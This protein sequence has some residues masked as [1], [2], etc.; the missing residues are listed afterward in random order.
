M[1]PQVQRITSRTIRDRGRLPSFS[2][3][4]TPPEKYYRLRIRF[5]NA[6]AVTQMPVQAVCS[7][8]FTMES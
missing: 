4:K 1:Y 5:A 3:K 8:A 7:R 2:D 6:T